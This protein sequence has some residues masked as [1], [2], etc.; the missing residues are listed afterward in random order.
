MPSF[1]AINLLCLVINFVRK[2][3]NKFGGGI[4]FYTDDHLPSWTI[5]IENAP[6]IEI[7]I[8]E[9]TICKN[10]NLVAGLLKPP[11]L[12]ETDFTTSLETIISKLSNSYEKLILMGDF[13]MTTT[14]QKMKF[15]I[16]N[17]FNKCDQIRRKLPIWSHLLK[18]SLMENFIFCAVWVIQFWDFEIRL[19]FH[20]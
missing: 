1:Q 17:F 18:K 12:S 14:A 20:L 10:K 5:K 16:K 4:A 2:D 6:G 15:S 3:R 9:I 19:H 11:N 8:M 13:Y 7:L